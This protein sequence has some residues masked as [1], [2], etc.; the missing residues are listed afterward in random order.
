MIDV[1]DA[2]DTYAARFVYGDLIV[3]AD[4]KTLKKDQH[5]PDP[6]L[7]S[8]SLQEVNFVHGLSWDESDNR[9]EGGTVYQ[10]STG[11]TASARATLESGSLNLRVYRGLPVAGRT[12]VFVRRGN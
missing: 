6:A 4:G 7:R 8:R 11:Q 9:W 3:E 1:Y 12:L 2:G 5:N 10:A